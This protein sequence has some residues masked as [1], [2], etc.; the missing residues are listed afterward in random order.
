MFFLKIDN[1]KKKILY[2]LGSNFGTI[3]NQQL[4]QSKISLKSN[5]IIQLGNIQLIFKGIFICFY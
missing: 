1:N 5:D 3:V 4:I 2:D